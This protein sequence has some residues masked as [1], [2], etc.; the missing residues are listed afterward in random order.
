M[1]IPVSLIL[2]LPLVAVG[3]HPDH[4]GFVREY[5]ESV[6]ADTDFYKLFTPQ[7]ARRIVDS[8]RPDMTAV[9]EVTGFN[10][11]GPGNYEYS[12]LF[13]NGATGIVSVNEREGVVKSAGIIVILPGM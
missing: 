13:S 10:S 6:Y 5:V 9:I 2:I 7:K 3:C 4:E 11:H 1:R 8:S 12:V